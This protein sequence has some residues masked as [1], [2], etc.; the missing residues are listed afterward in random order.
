MLNRSDIINQIASRCMI[1]PQDVEKG[2]KIILD[3]MARALIQGKR[4]EIRQFGAFTLHYH[5]PK[6]GRNPKTGE[7]VWIPGKYTVHFKP[8]KGLR[9]RVNDSRASGIPILDNSDDDIA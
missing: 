9:E 8:G 3:S 2:V 7:K 6:Q 4:I 5:P 1:S